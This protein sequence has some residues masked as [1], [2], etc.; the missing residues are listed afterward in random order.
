MFS[1]LTS[2]ISGMVAQKFG[3]AGDPNAAPVD[4]NAAPVDPNDPNAQYQQ[5]Q[6]GAEAGAEGQQPPPSGMGGLAQ[7]LMMKAMAG[8]QAAMEKAGALAAQ[9]Q[10]VT[11]MAG[12][13]MS[14]VTQLIPGRG[15]AEEAVPPVD[16]NA[17]MDPN[18]QGYE[19]QQ[20]VDDQGQYQEQVQ[21]QQ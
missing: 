15:A 18:A 21:Y 20:Y 2:Q 1:G 12:G 8:K 3:G 16:P 11:A 7:G 17:Q 13:M 4:P 19:Q 14:N 10:G 6:N 9:S 5:Q